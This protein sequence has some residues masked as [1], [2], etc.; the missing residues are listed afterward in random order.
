MYKKKHRIQKFEIRVGNVEGK[1]IIAFDKCLYQ[2]QGT[3]LP[4]TS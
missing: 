4:F 2:L 3:H 1:F